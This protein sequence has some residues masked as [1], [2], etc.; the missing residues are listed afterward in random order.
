MELTVAERGWASRLLW[1]W[2]YDDTSGCAPGIGGLAVIDPKK[3][4][5][6]L[7]TSP[8]APRVMLFGPMEADL[9]SLKA[10]FVGLSKREA[11]LD[12]HSLPFIH[13]VNVGLRLRSLGPLFYSKSRDGRQ[14]LR[15]HLHDPHTFTW[16]RTN[17]GWDYLAE[18]LDGLIKSQSA[19]HQ[20]LTRYPDEDA[21]VVV[22]KGEY[23]DDVLCAFDK[24]A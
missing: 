13:A 23:G 6:A 2:T 20:Y 17:E 12:L 24:R 1:P 5:L 8:D 16:S 11:E 14:G 3:I 21:I 19:G 4:R 10:C 15:R 18:L 22:S 7:Y 9:A